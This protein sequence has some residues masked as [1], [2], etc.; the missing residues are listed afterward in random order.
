MELRVRNYR[1]KPMHLEAALVLPVGWQASPEVLS[2][3]VPPNG[4]GREGF[5]VT[6]PETWDRSRPRVA[7]AADVRADGRYLGEITEAVVDLDFAG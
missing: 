1:S 5:M 4:E 6:I 2:L 7:L 3:T